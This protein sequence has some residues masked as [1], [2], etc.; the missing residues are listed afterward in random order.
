MQVVFEAGPNFDASSSRLL[1]GAVALR[2][3]AAPC[4]AVPA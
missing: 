4:A 1:S 2:A 3:V